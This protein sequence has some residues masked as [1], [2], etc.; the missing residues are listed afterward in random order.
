MEIVSSLLPHLLPGCAHLDEPA[1]ARV[2]Y[3]LGFDLALGGGP[4]VR[5]INGWTNFNSR[6]L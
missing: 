2:A 5:A 3:D 6:S 4:V 1:A